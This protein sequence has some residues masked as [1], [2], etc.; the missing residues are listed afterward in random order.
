LRKVIGQNEDMKK[1]V[2]VFS[3]LAISFLASAETVVVVSRQSSFQQVLT[4]D[5]V[6]DIFLGRLSTLPDTNQ[7]VV[8]VDQ[9]EGAMREDFYR[10]TTG[11][12]DA[13]LAAYWARIVFTGKGQRPQVV[14]NS[15]A[16]KKLLADNPGAV[17]Y[18]AKPEV[19]PSVK[20][21]FSV[22]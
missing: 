18:M 13:Q 4:A 12:S 8:P 2:V 1:A 22:E 11:Q 15:T 10:K 21:I 7:V 3:F 16:L 5:Q 9:P 14:P 6:K 19:D 17:G 20:V